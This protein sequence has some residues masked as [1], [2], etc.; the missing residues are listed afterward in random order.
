[1][2]HPANISSAPRASTYAASTLSGL[3]K[4]ESAA[5]AGGTGEA[6]SAKRS[7][8]GRITNWLVSHHPSKAAAEI[9]Q[10]FFKAVGHMFQAGTL[11]NLLKNAT[12]QIRSAKQLLA[13][14]ISSTPPPGLEKWH[15]LD[16]MKA[17]LSALKLEMNMLHEQAHHYHGEALKNPNNE[18]P[19]NAARNAYVMEAEVKSKVDSQERNVADLEKSLSKHK[20]PPAARMLTAPAPDRSAQTETAPQ[21]T[22]SKITYAAPTNPQAHLS[23]RE[24]GRL[25]T[26]QPSRQSAIVNPQSNARPYVPARGNR[27]APSF[28]A[29]AS[30]PPMNPAS[31][32]HA[33][34][35]A[36][37][38]GSLAADLARV[39][40]QADGSAGKN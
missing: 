8:M 39:L 18:K 31:S 36:P 19:M 17:N 38:A 35:G 28:L 14:T 3:Q 2:S 10:N 13:R 27:A 30:Q 15:E 23:L 40:S 33:A 6:T 12:D 29:A 16:K 7:F 20:R 22:A 25:S 26:M 11:S 5:K 9:K 37:R 34:T 4:D 21:A 1:M 32:A 24:R